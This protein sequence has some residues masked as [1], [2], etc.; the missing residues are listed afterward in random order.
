M[1]AIGSAVPREA[2]D[3]ELLDDRAVVEHF[4]DR[5][6]SVPWIQRGDGSYGKGVGSS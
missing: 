5:D 3:G 6:R 1:S 4:D 2:V